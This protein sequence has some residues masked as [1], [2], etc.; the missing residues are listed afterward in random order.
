[1]LNVHRDR[2]TNAAD[3]TLHHYMQ[4]DTNVQTMHCD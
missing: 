2:N 4:R 3:I 1:M